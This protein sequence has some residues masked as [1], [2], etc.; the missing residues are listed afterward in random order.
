MFYFDI[1]D[2][3]YR[4]RFEHTKNSDGKYTNTIAYLEKT[5]LSSPASVFVIGAGIAYCSSSDQF[6]KETG[7]KLAL[8]RILLDVFQDYNTRRLA[9]QAYFARKQK[10]VIET[11][12]VGC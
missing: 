7:R 5:E 8:S 1:A 9:W 3:R 12:P 10:S 6:C 11:E 4:V 2:S